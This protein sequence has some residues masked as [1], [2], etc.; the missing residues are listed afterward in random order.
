[1]AQGGLLFGPRSSSGE[2]HGV[3]AQRGSRGGDKAIAFGRRFGERVGS[4]RGP[5]SPGKLSQLRERRG[6]SVEHL[7]LGKALGLPKA[8]APGNEGVTND[9]QQEGQGLVNPFLFLNRLTARK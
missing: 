1:M 3:V 6:E 4:L 2:R 8:E 7:G 9:R 5:R